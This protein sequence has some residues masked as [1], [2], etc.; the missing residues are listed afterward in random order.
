MELSLVY[1][2]LTVTLI[3]RRR[4]RGFD[5]LGYV[6]SDVVTCFMCR[7]PLVLVTKDRLREEEH[8]TTCII[9]CLCHQR[10]VEE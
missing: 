8:L 7:S 6:N 10:Y 5:H 3:L 9:V 1:R 2:P 4:V